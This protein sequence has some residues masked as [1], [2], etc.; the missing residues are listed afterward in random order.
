MLPDDNLWTRIEQ[1]ELDEPDA[2][3]PFSARL[4]KE[5]GWTYPHTQRVIE[6][7]RRFVYLACVAGHPVSPADEVDEVWHLHLTYTESYWG[8]FCPQVID[9]P[10]HHQP[11]R[12]GR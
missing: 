12:G 11:T 5:T 9:R 10:L 6:E 7:Y 1:F 3:F 2:G 4:A 8:R